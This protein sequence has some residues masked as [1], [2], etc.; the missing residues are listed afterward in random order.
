VDGVIVCPYLEDA[1]ARRQL[2]KLA[3]IPVVIINHNIPNDQPWLCIG[4]AGTCSGAAGTCSGTAGT[5]I[6]TDWTSI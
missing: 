2:G 6:C 4:T 5:S 1:L 3:R